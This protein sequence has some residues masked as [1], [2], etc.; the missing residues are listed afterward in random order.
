MFDVQDKTVKR[1]RDLVHRK[2]LVLGAHIGIKFHNGKYLIDT[3]EKDRVLTLSVS[4]SSPIMNRLLTLWSIFN[5]KCLSKINID[6]SQGGFPILNYPIAFLPSASRGLEVWNLC[7]NRRINCIQT[8][9]ISYLVRNQFLFV[10]H[11]LSGISIYKVSQLM[12]ENY[13]GA[14]WTR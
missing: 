2:C 5:G 9:V 7:S 10:L 11:S 4:A 13:N 6:G 12:D 14:L 1:V 3:I 8:N